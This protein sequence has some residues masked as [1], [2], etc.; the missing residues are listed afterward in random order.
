MGV[1]GKG[2][3]TAV[4]SATASAEPTPSAP[5]ELPT[6]V[7]IDAVNVKSKVQAVIL[8]PDTDLS[9]YR[10][11][12]DTDRSDPEFFEKHW[13]GDKNVPYVLFMRQRFPYW[14]SVAQGG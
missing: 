6:G 7:E 11:L 13:K 8:D 2:S 4:A 1:G 12:P 10:Q 9:R 5:A 3:E 14:K